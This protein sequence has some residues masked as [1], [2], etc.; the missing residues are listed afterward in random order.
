MLEPALRLL[1]D[2]LGLSSVSD[3]WVAVRLFCGLGWELTE[4]DHFWAWAGGES[5]KEK[6]R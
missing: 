5:E 4:T 1:P 3:I 2:G 6:L